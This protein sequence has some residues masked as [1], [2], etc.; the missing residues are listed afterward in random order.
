MNK[1][2]SINCARVYD[3]VKCSIDRSS[4]VIKI[5]FILNREKYS[6]VDKFITVEYQLNANL[7]AFICFDS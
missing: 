4:D 1:F 5:P 6:D 7:C 3:E 2:S